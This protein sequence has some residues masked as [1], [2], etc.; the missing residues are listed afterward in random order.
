MRNLEVLGEAAR[1]VGADLRRRHPEVPWRALIGFRNLATHTYWTIDAE[2][3][4]K[5]VEQLPTLRRRIAAIRV[6][7]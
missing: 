1:E 3:I 5:F 4:W 2:R 6:S 7:D